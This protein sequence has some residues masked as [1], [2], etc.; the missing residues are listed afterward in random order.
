VLIGEVLMR[1][2]DPET[3]VRELT[4]SEEPTQA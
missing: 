4:R 1:A 2:P 3:A